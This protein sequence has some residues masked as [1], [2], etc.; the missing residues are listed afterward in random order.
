M[1]R[2]EIM[3]I[4]AF[5]DFL[6][7]GEK[8]DVGFQIPHLPSAAQDAGD[9]ESNAK[10]A[11]TFLKKTLTEHDKVYHPDGYNPKEDK[12]NFRAMLKKN[13][14]VDALVAEKPKEEAHL[15]L[16]EC[17]EDDNGKKKIV[18]VVEVDE[19]KA[20]EIKES[21]EDSASAIA[22]YLAVAGEDGK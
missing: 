7:K 3:D 15:G 21:S 2:K 22:K 4:G 20:E 1:E 10:M 13:D 14:N 12:C 17:L 11:K 19:K 16:V 5:K 9:M 6:A 18:D 8:S